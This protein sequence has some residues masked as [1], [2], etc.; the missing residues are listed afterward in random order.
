MQPNHLV[1]EFNIGLLKAYQAVELC[2]Y[3]DMLDE[4]HQR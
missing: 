1:D 3:H 2:C 4:C